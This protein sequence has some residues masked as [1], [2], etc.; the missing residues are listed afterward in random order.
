MKNTSNA[1]ILFFGV[2]LGIALTL[3]TGAAF[4]EHREAEGR[5]R[6]AVGSEGQAYLLDSFT[7][8]VWSRGGTP[9]ARKAFHAP[10]R[11][12]QEP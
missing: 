6:L 4:P 9:E 1:R 10:K 8:Q 12:S 11:P 5:Y 3:L 7:G 2:I